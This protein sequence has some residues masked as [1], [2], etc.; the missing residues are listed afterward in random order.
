MRFYPTINRVSIERG[1]HKTPTRLGSRP[2]VDTTATQSNDDSRASEAGGRDAGTPANGRCGQDESRAGGGSWLL[3]PL[4]WL[5]KKLSGAVRWVAKLLRAPLRPAVRIPLWLLTR[6]PFRRLLGALMKPREERG[7]GFWWLI[8]T[9]AIAGAVGLL[10]A[11]LLTPVA[12]IVA[13]L[14]VGVWAMISRLSGRRDEAKR[15]EQRRKP[16]PSVGA[17]EPAA[18]PQRRGAP[19]ATAPATG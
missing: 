8:A 17:S 11:A 14:V 2:R 5:R 16:D 15:Q 12:G 7:F 3:A 18:A 13:L 1:S 19:I 6:R 4:R 9:I 10:V